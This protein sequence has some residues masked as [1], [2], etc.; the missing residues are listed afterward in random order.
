LFHL[1][2]AKHFLAMAVLLSFCLAGLSFDISAA[3]SVQQ[4]QSE[5]SRVK[6]QIQKRKTNIFQYKRQE[7]SVIKTLART[8]QE[9]EATRDRLSSLQKQK[10]QV[11]NSIA[12]SE[13]ELHMAEGQLAKTQA[14]LD[15]QIAILSK[16]LRAIYIRGV[17]SYLELVLTSQDFTDFVSRFELLERLVKQDIVLF[18]R[19]E[20]KKKDVEEQKRQIEIRKRNL[21]E[22]KAALEELHRGVK[23]E[24]SR[25]K[26]KAEEHASY[27]KRVRNQ[28]ALEEQAL[29]ELEQVSAQLD[30]I[31]KKL[32]AK[33]KNKVIS[34]DPGKMS[35]PVKGR[36]TSPFGWRYHPIFKTRKYH[37]G[38]DI[39]SPYGTS[40]K[41]AKDGIVIFNGWMN[42]Y[43]K[44]II[45]DHGRGI[46]TL[47]AHC[48]VLVAGVGT[49][50][51]RGQIIAKVGT[52]GYATGPH[53]HFEVR[54]GGDKQNPTSYLQ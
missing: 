53:V 8:E 28:R 43:G 52:T 7:K 54:S 44:V 21:E 31:I 13:A 35:W 10:I 23:Q 34:N 51:S 38:I 30:S 22:R 19:V 17:G 6:N 5:L 37:S 46:S 39:A 40:I 41:A 4:K 29:D 47:Y 15:G 20:K 33:N 50:V 27:L 45:I 26:S 24:E 1:R 36:I 14:E 12:R 42:G 49:R 11:E 32:M 18:E 16:R 3:T 2:A 25:L 9:L 48:S